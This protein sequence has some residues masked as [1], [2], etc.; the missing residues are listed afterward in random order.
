[1]R[2]KVWRLAGTVAF[3]FFGLMLL[4]ITLSGKPPLVETV[5]GSGAMRFIS[6]SGTITGTVRALCYRLP[7]ERPFAD[8][9]LTVHDGVPAE[10]L[11]TDCNYIAALHQLHE[12]PSGKANHGPAYT[13]YATSWA[14]GETRPMT[15]TG[16]IMIR[17]V[18]PLTLFNVVVSLGWEPPPGTAVLTPNEMNSSLRD[19]SAALYNLTE[20]QMAFGEVTIHTG[21]EYWDSADIRVLPAND[22]RPS[23]YV[24]GIVQEPIL[25]D[26]GISS[27]LYSPAAIYLGRG[28]ERCQ[29]PCCAR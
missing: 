13:V 29:S 5:Y 7:E 6:E 25:Y 19:T 2:L 9:L 20:G 14:P 21:G 23:A 27:T 8:R 17:E 22:E 15:N 11:P 26:N 1:M 16:E 3:A 24:G 18:W 10:S 12:Q 28:V 4:I